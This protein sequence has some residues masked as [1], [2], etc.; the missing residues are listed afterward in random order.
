[1]LHTRSKWQRNTF[2]IWHATTALHFPASRLKLPNQSQEFITNHIALAKLVPRCLGCMGIGPVSARFL[3][4]LLTLSPRFSCGVC[5]I[6]CTT[7]PYTSMA[8]LVQ[9]A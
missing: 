3:F 8:V 9:L 4:S 6:R 5:A 2:D 7:A 1:M